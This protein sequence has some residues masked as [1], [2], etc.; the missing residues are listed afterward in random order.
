MSLTLLKWSQNYRG[1][2]LSF[3]KVDIICMSRIYLTAFGSYL[4]TVSFLKLE[5]HSVLDYCH[6]VYC[7]EWNCVSVSGVSHTFVFSCQGPSIR[8]LP[9]P[10]TQ[11]CT[12]TGEDRDSR[13]T[14]RSPQ[15]SILWFLSA[16]L[17]HSFSLACLLSNSLNYQS[18][19][20]SFWRYKEKC[21]LLR[22]LP[23]KENQCSYLV[24]FPFLV[25]KKNPLKTPWL[26]LHSIP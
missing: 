7:M 2:S 19:L 26:W 13:S 12:C 25:L 17:V 16:P 15:T 5:V 10:G 6:I 18:N 3:Y 8:R 24:L 4:L 9:F 23:Y 11:S 22:T 20:F 1:E 21:I 14:F